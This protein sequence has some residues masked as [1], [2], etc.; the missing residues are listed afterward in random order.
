L[1]KKY[2]EFKYKVALECGIVTDMFIN[3]T[4]E[5]HA[6]IKAC[7]EVR[8]LSAVMHV[9]TSDGKKIFW[10]EN[11][12]PYQRPVFGRKE[13]YGREFQNGEALPQG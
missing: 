11:G 9:K 3:D 8:F 1:K 13:Q 2:Q 6:N 7:K 4:D 10:R 12:I 5:E